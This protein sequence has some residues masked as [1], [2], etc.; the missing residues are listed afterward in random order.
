MAENRKRLQLGNI[1][2]ISPFLF[3]HIIIPS[4]G[5]VTFTRFPH[6]NAI[7]VIVYQIR[8][9]ILKYKLACL[10]FWACSSEAWAPKPRF[11]VSNANPDRQNTRLKMADIEYNSERIRNFSIIAH[12]DHGTYD[13]LESLCSW[14]LACRSKQLR[15][16]SGSILVNRKIH[17]G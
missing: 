1:D 6:S 16:Y 10:L 12:I 7:Y 14:G 5:T 15:L 11:A 9:I 8:M 13:S 17:P 4:I 2:E 3:Q